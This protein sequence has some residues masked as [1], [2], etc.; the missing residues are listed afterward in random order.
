MASSFM[1]APA[2]QTAPVQ[3]A[4][5]QRSIG[6]RQTSQRTGGTLSITD[7]LQRSVGNQAISRLLRS[8]AV[9]R[10]KFNAGQL[11]DKHECEADDVS[12]KVMRMAA[13]AEDH[14]LPDDFSP[15]HGVG[16]PLEPAT[17]AFMEPRF[18]H[19]FSHVRIHTD[20]RAAAS[21]R[22]INALAYTSGS[23]IVF[24]RG[25]YSPHS[26]SGQR[27]LS[28]ELTHVV[29]QSSGAQPVISRAATTADFRITGL[30]PDLASVEN[31]IRFNFNQASIPPV[32]NPKIAK[33]AKPAGRDI[34][35]NGYASE[36]G[37]AA[38]KAKLVNRR[39]TAVSDALKASGHKGP[40]HPNPDPTR[41]EG[42]IDYRGMRIVEIVDT[43]KPPKGLK[44]VPPI[45]TRVPSC[46]AGP[47]TPC[48]TTY[49]TAFPKADKAVKDAITKLTAPSPATLGHVA[50]HFG[51]TPAATLLTNITGLSTKLT[52]LNGIHSSATDCHLNA[53]DT[54]CSGA[55]AYVDPNVVPHRMIFCDDF[56]SQADAGQRGRTIIHEALHVTPGVMSKDLAYAHTR[57]IRTLTDPEKLTNTDSYVNLITI[58]HDPAAV[59]STPPADTITGTANPAETA[60]AQ[61]AIA[62]LEQWL[63]KAKFF[64][65]QLYENIDT[66]LTTPAHWTAAP[67]KW[68]HI[69]MHD[70]SP[71]FGLTDPGTTAPFTLPVRDDK[72]RMAG[73]ND[74]YVRMRN[75]F[76]GK[77]ITLTKITSGS[78]QWAADLGNKV[79]VKAPFF[80]MTDVNAIRHL[81]KLMLK[82]IPLDVSAALVDDYVEGANKIRTQGGIGP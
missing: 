75:V 49:S 72:I 28:H 16:Q 27:L 55:G 2:R 8:H 38:S 30:A 19:D 25:Q 62:F 67:K 70:L 45:P 53:C 76:Y 46:T 68:F 32:E 36:E 44:V 65:A 56:R 17:R 37:D 3:R 60:F 13:P 15:V 61:R 48:G 1:S 69:T 80:A 34:T 10:K 20:A 4:E 24:A 6:N 58:L 26:V 64:T 54:Q 31:V 51:A 39:I 5:S 47:S 11:D 33:Q 42:N 12:E 81:M 71:L 73:I 7:R 79:K 77:T 57:K 52:A 9:Q 43:P 74:R 59:L 66:G 29:Q 40:R 18:G 41:G 23:N 63:I 50:T 78:E 21:A 14:S 35:L 82:S 22:S